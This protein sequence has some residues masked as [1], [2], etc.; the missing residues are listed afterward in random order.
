MFCHPPFPNIALVN[1]AAFARASRLAD[2]QVFKL[3]VTTTTLANSEI[4]LV[5]MNSVPAEYHKLRDVFS[6][7]HADTLPT[8]Q[9]YNLKIELEE[10]ATPPFGPIYSLSPYKLWTL[11]E[12]INEH[13]TYSFI[14][15]L[16]SPCSAL[17]L[18]IKKDLCQFPGPQ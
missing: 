7:P 10:G 14:R 8:H 15:P 16:H 13:L 3:F 9:P 18:F 1:A 4:I 12:F 5:G 17:V 2:L 11:C 6:K